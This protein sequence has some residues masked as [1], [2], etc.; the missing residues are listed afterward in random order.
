MSDNN[1]LLER[2]PGLLVVSEFHSTQSTWNLITE[3]LEWQAKD[4]AFTVY[5]GGTEG[6]GVASY[7]RQRQALGKLSRYVN[8]GGP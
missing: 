6:Y 5:V 4:F 7:H 2:I 3:G 8:K 1:R